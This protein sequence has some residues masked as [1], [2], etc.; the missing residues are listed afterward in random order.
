MGTADRVEWRGRARRRVLA[1][2]GLAMVVFVVGVIATDL[3]GG[4]GKSTGGV[5]DN[6]SATS[7]VS[8]RR[9]LLSQQTQVSG[10]LG[11]A[12][13]SSIRVPSGTAPSGVQQASQQVANA[14]T[15]LA[16]ARATLASETQA[17]AGHRATLAAARAKEEVNCAGDGAAEAA[18]PNSSPAS[19][20]NESPGGSSSC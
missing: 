1:I 17:Q 13:S 15:M 2:A 4:P 11:Y 16:T 12:G 8:V 3:F 7:L 10:T 20:N 19:A 9:R 18:S 6:A 14:E 5:A